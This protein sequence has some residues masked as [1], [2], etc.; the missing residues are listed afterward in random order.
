MSKLCEVIAIESG[1]KTRCKEVETKAYQQLAKAELLYGLAR[2]YTP[3]NDEDEQLPAESAPVQL[4]ASEMIDEVVSH[5]AEMFDTTA[6]K[7]FGN[8][9]AKSDV[10]VDGAV[11]VKD[12]PVSYLLWLEKQ[13]TDLNTFISK[14]PTLDASEQ[15][16]F[17]KNQN[18][19]ATTPV[20]KLRSIKEKKPIVLY[21]ATPEHPAQTQIIEVDKVVGTW[22]TTKYSGCLPVT[23]VKELKTRV[24]KLQDAVKVARER[25]NQ[26][27]V[28]PQK[29]GQDVLSWL[30]A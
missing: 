10:V 26:T 3:K 14:L 13:L 20:Q 23:R 30:F 1:V 11:L 12:A 18:C 15:W 25:A 28:D 5:L 2:R 16:E 21:D 27:K 19:F 22:T 7:D 6:T 4:R 29:V 8:T 17:D 24:A 9:V